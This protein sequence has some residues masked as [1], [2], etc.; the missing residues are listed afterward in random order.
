MNRT[1]AQISLP[2]ETSESGLSNQRPSD[3]RPAS[4]PPFYLTSGSPLGVRTSDGGGDP[5]SG[6]Q[7]AEQV[8]DTEP[9]KPTLRPYQLAASDAAFQEWAKGNRR[10]LI[11]MAT[12]CG[13]TVLAADVIR[14]MSQ[15]GSRSLFV[16]HREELLEQTIDKLR[17]AGVKAELEQASHRASLAANVVVA[18]VQSLQRARLERFPRSH[19]GL[20]V[21][22]EAHHAAAKSYQNQL[23]HFELATV[24]GLTATPK[25]A[26]GKAL[27]KTFDS[28]A[29]TLPLRQ[30]IRD[31]WLA[32]LSIRRVRLKSLD[33]RGV[34]KSNGDFNQGELDALMSQERVLHETLAPLVEMA[35]TRKTIVFAVS[36]SHAHQ[37]AKLLIER[38]S[39]RAVALDGKSDKWWRKQVLREFAEGQ[40]QYLVNCSLFTEGFDEP[41]IECVGLARPTLSAGLYTQMIGRGTRLSKAT[42]KVD[43]LGLDFVGNSR[44]G[45]AGPLDALAGDDVPDDVR[46]EVEKMLAT[47]ETAA[48]SDLIDTATAAAADLAKNVHVIAVAAYRASEVDPFLGDHIQSGKPGGGPLTQQMRE[49]LVDLLGMKHPPV[50]LTMDEAQRWV[51]GARRRTRAGLCSFK[52]C[53]AL[54]RAQID[55]KLVAKMTIKRANELCGLLAV[56]KPAWHP[57]ALRNEPER[58]GN[59]R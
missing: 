27:G 11:V 1:Q 35:G 31:G 24:L 38:Y 44:F 39:K 22:D 10:T 45:L 16:A 34:S 17:K 2:L 13:K 32:P 53:K 56:H 51:D 42:G 59:I 7:T 15:Q 23:E 25:R 58:R 41:S 6:R 49:Q 57:D 28:V 3:V 55:E 9:E 8:E 40:H 30:A 19:F 48:V 26:D 12:G 36:V 20:V 29:F 54:R 37:M 46:E 5:D 4:G 14:R 50:Q 18:S 52:Q 21:V 43:C 47:G 33:L